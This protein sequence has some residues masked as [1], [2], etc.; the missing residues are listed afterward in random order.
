[1]L[2]GQLN[3]GEGG[4]RGYKSVCGPWIRGWR[5]L[6]NVTG[7][8]IAACI[9]R[10]GIMRSPDMVLRALKKFLYP[11]DPPLPLPD[12]VRKYVIFTS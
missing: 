12:F 11:R 10:K 9:A 3:D 5:V 4:S 1:M 7:V 6:P 2:G 8:S